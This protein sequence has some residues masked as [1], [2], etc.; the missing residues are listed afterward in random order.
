MKPSKAQA[1]ASESTTSQVDVLGS[2]SRHDSLPARNSSCAPPPHT[3]FPATITSACSPA[4]APV[5]LLNSAPLSCFINKM[6]LGAKIPVCLL[7]PFPC[8]CTKEFFRCNVTRDILIM[9]TGESN[10]LL[11]SHILKIQ[12]ARLARWLEGQGSRCLMPSLTTNFL[13][14]PQNPLGEGKN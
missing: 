14:R 13:F 2:L 9:Q 12:N 4:P 6:F 11:L 5:P 8:K 1:E 3:S 7:F 10:Y